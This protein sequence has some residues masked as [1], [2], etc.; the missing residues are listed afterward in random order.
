MQYDIIIG[1]VFNDSSVPFTLTTVEYAASL[2]R[3]LTPD[4]VVAVN[5]IAAANDACLPFLSS[6]HRS[7]ASA[8]NN[9]LYYPLAEPTAL[10]VQNIIGVYSN[11]P[12]RWADSLAGSSLI[13]MGPGKNLTDN[14]APV[15]Y[16]KQRCT[17]R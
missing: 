14:Y 4:G 12:L 15:E 8:F 11:N 5:I 7:Y 2:K 16:L 13:V 6:L 9:A 3:A 1:D 10:R 17:A